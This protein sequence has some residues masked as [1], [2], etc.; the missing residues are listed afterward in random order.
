MATKLLD[1]ANKKAA[2]INQSSDFYGTFAEIGAGQEVSRFFFREALSSHTIAKSISAYDMSVSTDIYGDTHRYVSQERLQ[3]IFSHEKE[4]LESRCPGK[5]GLFIF[6][7]TVATITRDYPQ[8]HGWLGVMFRGKAG[9]WNQFSLHVVLK[10]K[11]RSFQQ[12]VLGTLGVN[13]MYA[14]FYL[15]KEPDLFLESLSCGIQSDELDIDYVDFK[16][17]DLEALDKKKMNVSLVKKGYCSAMMLNG[18]GNPQLSQD[19]LFGKELLLMRDFF[20]PVTNLHVDILRAGREQWE[21][22]FSPKNAVIFFEMHLSSEAKDFQKELE[23][24]EMLSAMNYQVLLTAFAS[25]DELKAYL[26]RMTDKNITFLVEASFLSKI[27]SEDFTKNPSELLSFMGRL[28]DQNTFFYVYPYK[29][30]ALC[31][32][33]SSFN[34]EK[35]FYYV[36]QFLR[37]QGLIKDISNCEDVNMSVMNEN[38]SALFAKGDPLWRTLVPLEVQ[39]VIDSKKIKDL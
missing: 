22:Q 37:D 23:A 16:G 7:N 15:S 4:L 31:V 10:L 21:Q 36:Y 12:N 28:L 34:P 35:P 8:G 20:R 24:I 13:L 5:K 25:G 18:Q 14:C 17:S 6:A 38:V 19:Y 11:S 9:H 39:A 30:E 27:F 2:Y 33:A 32:T 1:S 3:Q 29:G 26:R